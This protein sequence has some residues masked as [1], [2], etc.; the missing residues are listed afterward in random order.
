MKRYSWRKIKKLIRQYPGMVDEAYVIGIDEAEALIQRAG[1][2]PYH[3]MM[4]RAMKKSGLE[5]AQWAPA[6]K[7]I[8]KSR[9]KAAAKDKAKSFLMALQR[10]RRLVVA[11]ACLLLLLGFFTL[12]PAG[13]TLAGR[14]AD[15]VVE[16]FD[17]RIQFRNDRTTGAV[18][19]PISDYNPDDYDDEYRIVYDSYDD[20]EK[21]QGGKE[22]LYLNA[23][24][25]EL[26]KIEVYPKYSN[27]YLVCFYYM[28]DDGKQVLLD[29]THRRSLAMAGSVSAQEAVT[30]ARTILGEFPIYCIIDLSDGY[31][32]AISWIGKLELYVAAEDGVDHEKLLE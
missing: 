3:E 20:F 9:R 26:E 31:F 24:F 16:M 22:Y 18:P 6:M 11:L 32:S 21:E 13:R 5:E 7:S 19:E 14:V 23:E 8:N 15:I 27:G 4:E 2:L 12:V 25:A 28:T 17:N 1:G 29:Q 10:R 30:F